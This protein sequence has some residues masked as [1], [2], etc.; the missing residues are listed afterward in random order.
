MVR[1]TFARAQLI[2]EGSDLRGEWP[3]IRG[4][5]PLRG[6]HHPLKSLIILASFCL[7]YNLK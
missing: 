6:A 7:E 1:E 4:S 2:H 3:V 5:S